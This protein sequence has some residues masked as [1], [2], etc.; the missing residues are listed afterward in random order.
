MSKSPLNMSL[1]LANKSLIKPNSSKRNKP[2]IKS[3]RY[4]PYASRKNN[5]SRAKPEHHLNRS[6]LKQR[7]RKFAHSQEYRR[8]DNGNIIASIYPPEFSLLR[9]ANLNSSIEKELVEFMKEN[10]EKFKNSKMNQNFTFPRRIREPEIPAFD[11]TVLFRR[12]TPGSSAKSNRRYKSQD[13]QHNYLLKDHLHGNNRQQKPN[14]VLGD[15]GSTQPLR[16]N[17]KILHNTL[18]FTNFRQNNFKLNINNSML[19]KNL[20]KLSRKSSTRKKRILTE[21]IPSNASLK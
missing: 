2:T 12:N 9:P 3:N 11:K 20:K 17:Q 15:S 14:F 19:K 4:T 7:E 6:I 8:K 13:N 1:Q 21:V 5:H 16:K 10:E 18:N